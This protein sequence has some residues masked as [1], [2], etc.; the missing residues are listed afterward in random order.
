M[1]W[2]FW[3]FYTP[4]FLFT[5]LPLI[6]LFS[7]AR[8]GKQTEMVKIKA[9]LTRLF[10]QFEWLLIPLWEL[11]RCRFKSLDFIVWLQICLWA[12]GQDSTWIIFQSSKRLARRRLPCRVL[13]TMWNI[14]NHLHE[15]FTVQCGSTYW[16]LLVKTSKALLL[17]LK[18]CCVCW[19]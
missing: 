8:D 9:P 18:P 3:G 15:R 13:R 1:I 4:W 6:W 16:L 17:Q 5:A 10:I 11:E 19:K 12:L 7:S 2:Y 14:S